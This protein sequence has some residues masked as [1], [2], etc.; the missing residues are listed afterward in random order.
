MKIITG[1][2]TV[3][4]ITG[5][6][7]SH[8][9]S[10]IDK[11]SNSNYRMRSVKVKDF[12]KNLLRVKIKGDNLKERFLLEDV[13]YHHKK[14]V[15]KPKTADNLYFNFELNG[16]E[17]HIV[18]GSVKFYSDTEARFEIKSESPIPYQDTA[19]LTLCLYHNLEKIKD[20]QAVTF[21]IPQ[22][23]IK[24]GM[25][26]HISK[27]SPAAGV[28]G[29]TITIEGEN[30]GDNIDN[31]YLFYIHEEEDPSY[32]FKERL[33]TT[34]KAIY[35]SKPNPKT[36]QQT[37]RFTLSTTLDRML[38]TIKAKES[39]LFSHLRSE[40]FGETIKLK[41][42]INSQPSEVKRYVVLNAHWKKGA[43]I[44][45]LI[46]L[47]SFLGF[48]S[49][50]MK[51]F[52]FFPYIFLDIKTNTYSLSRFQAFI[53]TIVLLGS[54]CYVAICWG[55]ILQSGEIPD[56]NPSLLGLMAISYGGLLSST[57]IEN[58][59]SKNELRN[60]Q[61]SMRNLICTGKVID[62]A[63]L[64]LFGFTIVAIFVYIY[65]LLQSNILNG[66]PDIPVTLHGLLTTSQTGY[67]AAKAATNKISISFIS[68]NKWYVTDKEINLKLV[69]NGFTD[70]MQVLI[71]A[72]GSPIPVEKKDSGTLSCTIHIPENTSN[73]LGFH[74]LILLLPGGG[75]VVLTDGIEIATDEIPILETEPEEDELEVK[76]L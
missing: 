23:S 50:I 64:Q 26:P 33:L 69:G 67:I 52:N 17:L 15:K 41:L 38:H 5:A 2:L 10:E 1:I 63:R 13:N 76:N 56:F 43:V 49:F 8:A 47:L 11:V 66:L 3:F 6:L 51:R 25:Q 40:I 74:D 59:I 44:I 16:E 57:I 58:K 14:K 34:R 37:L 27:V 53:W 21:E 28:A 65:N 75:S 72:I 7:H 19:T 31:I 32:E 20:L 60:T 61:P 4:L 55:L 22:R 39:N 54:Y 24:P 35:L 73:L 48:I 42:M 36:N 46:V 29:D 12:S 70:D 30:F 68:P 71:E 45:S 18:T 62:L 9:V